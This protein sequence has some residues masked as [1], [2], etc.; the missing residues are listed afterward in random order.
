M[1]NFTDIRIFLIPI[2][3]AERFNIIVY[4]EPVEE[5]ILVYCMSGFYMPNFI[6]N[7]FN[8]T[9]SIN[10]RVT[11]LINWVIDSLRRQGGTATGTKK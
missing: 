6:V 8:L 1:T 10:T 2:M 9:L 5:G 7:M 4:L 3:R 11:I